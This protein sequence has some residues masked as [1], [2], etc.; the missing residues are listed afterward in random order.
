MNVSAYEEIKGQL[1]QTKPKIK[2]NQRREIMFTAKFLG[3]FY[4]HVFSHNLNI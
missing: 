3:F 2:E 4:Y 1:L